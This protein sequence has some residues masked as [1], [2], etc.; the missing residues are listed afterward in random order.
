[1]EWIHLREEEFDDAVK[2]SG[3]VCVIPMGCVEAHGQH[4]P[5]GCDTIKAKEFT[6]RAAEREPV[7]V[8]PSMYFGEKSGAGE[9]KGTIIFPQRLIM[10]ILEQSCIEI[11]RNGFKKI[12][13]I[14][15]HGG[16]KNIV[17]TFVRSIV[18]KNYDFLVYSYYQ[19]MPVP[20]LILS[21]LEKYPYLTEED[22]NILKSHGT[23][24][25][26]HGCFT[27]TGWLY[28]IMPERVRLDRAEQVD[29][30]S[31]HLFDEFDNLGLYTPFAWMGNYPNSYE[32]DFHAGMNE[33]IARAMGER[34]VSQTAEMFKFLKNETISVE[35]HKQWL[36][37]NFG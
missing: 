15:A 33:R 17:G 16:N 28:D 21:E 13:I 36:K 8:F 20:S 25:S 10:D 14:N 31:T 2:K 19:S 29:G 22:I 27:E 18:Q 5:L 12:V 37:K 4:L 34:T 32:G 26:G 3:G 23:K 7:C 1:M 24:H 9:F 6:V 30:T 11:A 35:Y